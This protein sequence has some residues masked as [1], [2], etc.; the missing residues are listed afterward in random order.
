MSKLQLYV[1]GITGTTI[2]ISCL[3]NIKIRDLK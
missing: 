1:K 2:T 3:N